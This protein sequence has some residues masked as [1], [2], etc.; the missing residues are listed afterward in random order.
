ME[1]LVKLVENVSEEYTVELADFADGKKMVKKLR[2]SE[3]N[4]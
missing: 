4:C 2:L 3:K 1:F